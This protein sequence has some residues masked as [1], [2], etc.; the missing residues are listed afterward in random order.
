M[1]TLGQLKEAT[2][3]KSAYASKFLPYVIATFDRF[4]INT[5]SRMLNFLA[6]VGHESGGLFYTEELASG[7]AYEGRKDLGNTQ[8]G[9]GVRFKGR[10]L[11]QITG[12]ANYKSVSLALGTDF[13]T[14]PILLGGKNVT[15]CN[16]IQLKN[17]AESAGWFW[18]SR[19]LNAL[20]DQIDITKNIDS[21]TNLVV[22]KKIT[23]TINGGYNGLPDRLNRYKSGLQYF[24]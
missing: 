10:G 8:K 22:F 14:N 19:N 20:A 15:K 7:S 17:A 1:L 11:I 3:A 5:P 24:L 13:I 6:Q 2:C 9:D 18:S 12:R 23:K 16:D 4:S 21:G